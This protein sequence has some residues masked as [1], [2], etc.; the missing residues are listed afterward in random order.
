ML[1]NLSMLKFLMVRECILSIISYYYF[2]LSHSYYF[3]CLF[4]CTLCYWRC[5]VPASSL[6]GAESE[7][8]LTEGMLQS[9]TVPIWSVPNILHSQ[10]VFYLKKDECGLNMKQRNLNL[11]ALLRPNP[12]T[13]EASWIMITK[14]CYCLAG[15]QFVPFLLSEGRFE[16]T[17]FFHHTEPNIGL[18]F[19]L[20][21]LTSSIW[22]IY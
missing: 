18:Y 20:L 13:Q 19:M 22:N 4:V 6:L 12:S 17:C 1:G 14:L 15:K 21:L 16:V 10:L 5:P 7:D 9:S 11:Y 3:Y 2:L 8:G